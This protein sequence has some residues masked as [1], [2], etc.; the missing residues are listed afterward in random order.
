MLLLLLVTL[1]EDQII[2]TTMIFMVGDDQTQTVASLASSLKTPRRQDY[3]VNIQP[4]EHARPDGLKLRSE[5]DS[6]AATAALL[7]LRLNNVTHQCR[8]PTLL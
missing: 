8:G 6:L 7:Y 2:T 3:P 4:L 5:S 1:V